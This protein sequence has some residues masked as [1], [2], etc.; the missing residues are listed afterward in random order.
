METPEIVLRPVSEA[1]VDHILG[2]VNDREIVGNI[3]SFSGE[4]F[5]R[6]AEL[7]YVRAMKVSAHDRVF[8]IFR[9]HDDAYLGQCGIHQIHP[10]SRVGRLSC[11]IAA[12]DLMGH[13]Y[14]TAAVRAV[15]GH[16]F[17]VE[18]LHKVW[19]MIFRHNTRS[20]RIYGRIGFVD[21]GVLREEYFHDGAWHD[22][23][24]M[25]LLAREWYAAPGEAVA[26]P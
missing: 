22:M 14:G 15:L 18:K 21:E 24:R 9:T 11:I 2:W 19:L 1:D 13:G 4:A 5:T 6:E 26:A 20:H 23:V 10:R 25:S 7:A 8:S 3:A 16:A 12:R 17:D